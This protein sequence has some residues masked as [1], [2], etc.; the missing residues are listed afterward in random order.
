MDSIRDVYFA[1]T[2]YSFRVHDFDMPSS[3]GKA[4]NNIEYSSIEE[5]QLPLTYLTWE[6]QIE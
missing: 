2:H 5:T 3:K 6:E 1:H 4:V